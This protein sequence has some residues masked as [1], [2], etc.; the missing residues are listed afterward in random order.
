MAIIIIKSQQ[1]DCFVLLRRPRKDNIEES[2]ESI[3][4]ILKT[5]LIDIQ[6]E[7]YVKR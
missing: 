6:K 3:K 1:R 7:Q 4:N 5:E 2:A